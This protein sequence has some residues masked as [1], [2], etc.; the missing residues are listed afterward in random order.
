MVN[1]LFFVVLSCSIMDQIGVR[2]NENASRYLARVQRGER[3]KVTDRG[4]PVALL[5]PIGSDPW[6]ELISQGRVI[7]A[8]D[9]SS[10]ADEPPLTVTSAPQPELAEMREGER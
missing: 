3:L 5:V 1:T 7:P 10:P 9:T 6:E 4:R 2:C 8:R